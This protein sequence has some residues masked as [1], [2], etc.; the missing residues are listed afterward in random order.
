MFDM[1]MRFLAGDEL[2]EGDSTDQLRIAVAALLVEAARMD[3]HFDDVERETI[4]RLLRQRF[5]LAADGADRLL[6]AAERANAD[7]TQLFRF[8]HLIVERLA[9][10][11][12]VRV[13]EMLW[14][15]VY[16]D[17]VLHPAED[18]LVRRVAGLIYVSDRDRGEARLR[19]VRRLGLAG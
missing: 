6:E 1:I 8:T 10:E 14:E 17:G 16:A 18:A 12:R 4:D 11:Q 2:P 3:E 13:I 15:V 7:S 19:V 5:G 9:P